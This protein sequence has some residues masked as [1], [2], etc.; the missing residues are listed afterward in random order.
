MLKLA[1]INEFDCPLIVRPVQNGLCELIGIDPDFDIDITMN[2]FIMNYT[3]TKSFIPLYGTGIYLDTNTP[4]HTLAKYSIQNLYEYSLVLFYAGHDDY[5]APRHVIS[6]IVSVIINALYDLKPGSSVYNTE[7]C[8]FTLNEFDGVYKGNPL[9]LV[10]GVR[11]G[12]QADTVSITQMETIEQSKHDIG[13]FNYVS[14]GINPEARSITLPVARVN[15][16]ELSFFTLTLDA[17]G[18]VSELPGI[19][20]KLGADNTYKFTI[21]GA[22]PENTSLF[23]PLK[24]PMV[25]EEEEMNVRT[26]SRSRIGARCIQRGTPNYRRSRGRGRDRE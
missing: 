12:V 18:I 17:S 10:I 8:N 19:E 2:N 25:R 9:Y 20:L 13:D 4:S 24:E 21:E 3:P 15:D 5:D 23:A 22:M 7:H 1:F 16:N 11:A 6:R 26:Y 14:F